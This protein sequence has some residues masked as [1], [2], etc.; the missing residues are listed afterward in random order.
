MGNADAVRRQRPTPRCPAC[1]GTG[2][3][4]L[5][6]R[7]C[8]RCDGYGTDQLRPAQDHQQ[9]E[10]GDHADLDEQR[11]DLGVRPHVSAYTQAGPS[12][13]AENRPTPPDSRTGRE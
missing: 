3:D 12:S 4:P 8:E 1:D 11:D 13:H 6:D 10:E 2:M 9:R 7:P 5:G